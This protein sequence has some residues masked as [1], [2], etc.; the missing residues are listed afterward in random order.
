MAFGQIEALEHQGVRLAYERI[1]GAAPHCVVIMLTSFQY[2][3][4]REIG[5]VLGASAFFHKATEF[6]LVPSFLNSLVL[7]AR[8][9]SVLNHHD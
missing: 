3:P 2:G 4:F 5:R 7:E 8:R 6:E 1:K 9:P